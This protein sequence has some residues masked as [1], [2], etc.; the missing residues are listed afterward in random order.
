MSVHANT[1]HAGATL[2]EEFGERGRQP[3][4]GFHNFVR[5]RYS[6]HSKYTIHFMGE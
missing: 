2:S 6:G 5:P 4:K 1:G 3:S